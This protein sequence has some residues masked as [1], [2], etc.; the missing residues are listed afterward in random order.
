MKFVDVKLRSDGI[1]QFELKPCDEFAIEDLIETNAAADLLG[2]GKIYPRLTLVN[3]F[4][5]FDKDVRALMATEESNHTTSAAAFVVNLIAIKIVG[6]FYISFNKPVR[7]TKIFDS[8]EKAVEW[9][10]T[11]L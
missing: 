2:Q 6:N 7:P 4:V 9:L 1:M 5:I 8:E 3:H 10:K 11:F